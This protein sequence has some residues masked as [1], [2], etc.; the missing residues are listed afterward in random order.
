MI[1]YVISENLIF[2]ERYDIMDYEI[3]NFNILT[4][5]FKDINIIEIHDNKFKM[6]Y[7]KNL[8]DEASYYG[9]AFVLEWLKKSK[10]HFK[11]YD[12]AINN[13]S[14][15]GHIKILEWFKN[16]GIELLY[17]ETSIDNAAL[18]SHIHICLIYFSLWLLLCH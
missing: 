14:Y 13:A 18:N 16:S 9:H 11:H 5:T 1:K 8:I 2:N 3:K 17:D 12:N 7:N 6:L 15:R 10:F 4:K